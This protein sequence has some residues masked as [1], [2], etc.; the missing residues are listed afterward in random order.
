M[1]SGKSAVIPVLLIAIGISGCG[2]KL[3]PAPYKVE[4]NVP[5][6]YTLPIENFPNLPP[7][8]VDGNR[9]SCEMFIYRVQIEYILCSE[10]KRSDALIGGMTDGR[11]RFR[12]PS[13]CD[14]IIEGVKRGLHNLCKPNYNDKL[15]ASK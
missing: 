5:H 2:N 4:I 13:V 8:G 1:Q 15:G 14:V 6:S 11:Q 12:I 3:R 9:D 7:K 10:Y